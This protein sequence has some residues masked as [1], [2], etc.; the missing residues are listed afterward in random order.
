MRMR[1]PNISGMSLVELLVY[2]VIFSI[3]ST[4]LFFIIRNIQTLSARNLEVQSAYAGFNI[5]LLTL[6][7]FVS[8]NSITI[9]PSSNPMPITNQNNYCIKNNVDNSYYFK[10]GYLYKGQNCGDPL[11]PLEIKVVGAQ[12]QNGY[13]TE[14]PAYKQISFHFSI[15]NL[16]LSSEGISAFVGL[17]Q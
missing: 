10:D 16:N 7:N 9:V 4:G 5:A 17:N 3:V 13:F 12:F 11:D 14:I 15:D 8:S 1:N 6:D 2:M